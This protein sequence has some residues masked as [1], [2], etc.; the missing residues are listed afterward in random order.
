MRGD[1]E[2][3]IYESK[4]DITGPAWWSGGCVA[5]AA[6]GPQSVRGTPAGGVQHCLLEMIVL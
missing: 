5:E 1:A 3:L 4:A 2:P 6:T